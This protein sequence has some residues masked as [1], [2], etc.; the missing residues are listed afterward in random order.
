[1]D[2]PL[3]PN[4]ESAMRDLSNWKGETILVLTSQYTNNVNPDFVRDAKT[5][6]NSATLRGLEKRGLIR[7][8]DA[9]WR[10]ATVTVLNN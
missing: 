4:Q 3:T 7:I 8:D 2:R 5:T 1:M 6:I 10:G 9:Y